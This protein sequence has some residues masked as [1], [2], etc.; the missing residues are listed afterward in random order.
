M[1]AL[2]A[3]S[4][5]WISQQTSL[6]IKSDN[7]SALVMAARLKVTSSQLIA[8]EL[9]MT[10]SEASF[11]PRHVVHVPGVMNVW[12]DALSRLDAPGG[13]YRIP[14]PLVSVPRAAP[15]PRTVA[16]HTTLAAEQQAG[17]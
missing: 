6:T 11:M 1:V 15:A 14:A 9:A 10:L 17:R 13:S 2:R 12:A 5:H 7:V 3:W 16:C 4:T 8:R